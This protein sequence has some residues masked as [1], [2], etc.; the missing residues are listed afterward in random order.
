M[1]VANSKALQICGITYL[2]KDELTDTNATIHRNGLQSSVHVIGDRA[3]D[4]VL[5][6]YE[7]VL[8]IMHGKIIGTG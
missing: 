3:I 1:L 8:K 7:S 2:E 4:V 5:D 6:A